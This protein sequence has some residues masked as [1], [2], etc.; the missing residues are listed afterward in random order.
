MSRLLLLAGTEEAA[1]FAREAAA[2]FGRRVTLV[3]ALAGGSERPAP[4]ADLVRIG[5]FGGAAGLARYL[6]Q[7]D[8]D[9]VVDASDPFAAALSAEARQACARAGVARLQLYPPP[10]PR[11]PLDRWIEV[12]E[13]AA[14]ARAVRHVGRR[15]FVSLGAAAL[16][17][18]APL[19]EVNFLV[20]LAAAPRAKLP[21][22]FYE[23]AIGRGPFS[24]AEERHLFERHAIEVVVARASGGAAPAASLV[25]A[26][27]ASLPVV[28][29]RRPAAE[30]GEVAESVEAALGWV[31]ARLA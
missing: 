10:W 11:D 28:M 8:I 30:P 7:E 14:A 29:L 31:G 5:G 27:E 18:F 19:H 24:P 25:A 16:D 22:R 6:R 21:L 12:E 4:R 9:L 1:L 23:L 15:A 13:V 17:G 20:R 26:R 2:R 3:A